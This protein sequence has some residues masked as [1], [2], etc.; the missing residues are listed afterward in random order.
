MYERMQC[1]PLPLRR[2]EFGAAKQNRSLLQFGSRG[3]D[4]FREKRFILMPKSTTQVEKSW[5]DQKF[6]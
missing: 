3:L 5:M 6:N 2:W 4:G 1:E